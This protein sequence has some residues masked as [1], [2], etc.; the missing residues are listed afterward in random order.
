MK[1][2]SA[3][4]SVEIGHLYLRDLRSKKSN[5][6]KYVEQRMLAGALAIGPTIRTYINHN[7]KV[8]TSVL[9]DDYFWSPGSGP[10]PEDLAELIASCRDDFLK[11][12]GISIDFIVFESS[13]AD[14]A[15]TLHRNITPLPIKDA[16]SGGSG[17]SELPIWISN[18]QK[19]RP[20]SSHEDVLPTIGLLP[21][22]EEDRTLSQSPKEHAVRIEVELFSGG[23]DNRVWSCPMLAAWWQLVRLG[24]LRD[25][26]DVPM[27]PARTIDFTEGEKTFFAKRTLTALDPQFLE[28]EVAV[29]TIL[30]NTTLPDNWLKALRDRE[31][32]LKPREHLDRIAYVFL[33]DKFHDVDMEKVDK[34]I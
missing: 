21:R 26:G 8:C 22:Q 10:S 29:R 30:D 9:I 25:E 16:G 23:K 17:G 7:K 33:S 18:G 4:L 13:L 2:K 28:I 31:E 27:I 20:A 11:E 34:W 5:P 6:T 12:L 32:F 1:F 19:R 24:M 15:T 14:T 3:D